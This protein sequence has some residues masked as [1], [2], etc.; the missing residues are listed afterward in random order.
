LPETAVFPIEIEFPGQIEVLE[1]TDAAGTG[2]VVMVTESDF[3]HP[4]EFLSDKV[5]EVVE[6]GETE[7]FETSELNP[8]AEL[9]HE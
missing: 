2:L 4:F 1:I 5:Y 8:E 9:N 6:V 3:T 7:G